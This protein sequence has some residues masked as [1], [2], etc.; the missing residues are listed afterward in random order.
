MLFTRNSYNQVISLQA[1]ILL[2]QSI[3][4]G[5]LTE[6]FN[7]EEPT[8]VD[9]RN[10]YFYALGNNINNCILSFYVVL[11]Q[12]LVVLSLVVV[13]MHSHSFLMGQ[14]MSMIL[15]IITTAAVYKKVCVVCK[16]SLNVLI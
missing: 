8:R 13:I 14:K 11:F 9:T 4:L 2:L 15:R 12:G 5:L 3:I 16:I 7:I 1:G 10:A 6:Y